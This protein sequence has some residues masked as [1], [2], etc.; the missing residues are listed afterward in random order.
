M[1]E[2]RKQIEKRYV[3]PMTADFNYDVVTGDAEEI[4][5]K[6]NTLPFMS[7]KR[8]VVVKDA[9]ALS[10]DPSLDPFLDAVFSIPGSTILL[11]METQTPIKKTQKLYKRFDKAHRVIAME[12]IKGRSLRNYL[13]GHLQKRGRRIK[14]DVL[15]H[16]IQLSGYEDR[17]F[18]GDLQGLVN[19]LD[20]IVGVCTDGIT[21]EAVDAFLDPFSAETVFDLLAAIAR[22]DATK[23]FAILDE[24]EAKEEPAGRILYM[25]ARQTGNLL[26]YKIMKE[27]GRTDGDIF[28]LMGV[29]PYEGKKIAAQ[30]GAYRKEQL[31]KHYRL[32]LDE[33]LRMKSTSATDRD[34]LETLLLS[35]LRE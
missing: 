6:A 23:I 22:K 26:Y 32:I 19:T 7:E 28:R 15:E 9:G 5:A 4:L 12:R 35:M 29:K 21:F 30:S 3:D 34:V 18:T 25:I 17:Q 33:E 10:G 2:K 14:A 16:F 11:L 31:K 27:T 20:Q 1:E 13:A 24:L 8:L